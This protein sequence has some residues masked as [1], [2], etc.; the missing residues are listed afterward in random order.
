MEFDRDTLR[1][2]RQWP[3]LT[4]AGARPVIAASPRES[5]DARLKYGPGRPPI[6]PAGF[7][8]DRGRATAEADE[9]ELSAVAS[10]E[11]LARLRVDCISWRGGDLGGN[12]K[13]CT[14]ECEPDHRPAASRITCVTSCGSS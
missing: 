10:I 8:D 1:R 4:E 6:A 9:I 13:E 2:T 14:C 7:E 11:Q 5:G 12:D 3:R